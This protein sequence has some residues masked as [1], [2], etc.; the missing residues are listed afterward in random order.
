M[1]LQVRLAADDELEAVGRL[2]LGAYTH[3]GYILDD[4]FYAGHLLDAVAR[5]ADAELLVADLDGHVRGTVTFC[6]EGSSFRERAAAGEGEFRML[7]VHPDARRRGVAE[8]LVQRCLTR[9]R[10][11]GYR[12]VVISSLPVQVEAHAL[13]GR[14]GFVRVPGLDWSPAP[15]VELLGFRLEL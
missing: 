9:S 4:D 15:G 8:A 11:L 13:Y 1:G 10:E 3:S 7:A 14:L 12:A 2:T 5:A 6:P